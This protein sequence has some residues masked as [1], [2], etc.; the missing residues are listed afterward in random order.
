MNYKVK[1]SRISFSKY[2]ISSKDSLNMNKM[3]LKHMNIDDSMIGN[4]KNT[5]DSVESLVDKGSSYID[6]S[7]KGITKTSSEDTLCKTFRASKHAM[8]SERDVPFYWMS[9]ALPDN[10]LSQAVSLFNKHVGKIQK[11][12]PYSIGF[13]GCGVDQKPFDESAGRVSAEGKQFKYFVDNNQVKEIGFMIVTDTSEFTDSTSYRG[14]AISKLSKLALVEKIKPRTLKA[15][16]YVKVMNNEVKNSFSLFYPNW[17][18]V[19]VD[20]LTR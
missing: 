8:E 4:V 15:T 6:F 12:V 11:Y 1:E 17:Y 16:S 5:L 19:L 14:F 18:P 3:Y 7:Y 13:Y 20:E 2:N 9:G 10:D